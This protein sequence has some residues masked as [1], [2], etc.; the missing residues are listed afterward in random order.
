MLRYRFVATN[1]RAQERRACPE[2]RRACVR[3][4]F[5]V[6]I[7]L[8]TGA[9]DRRRRMYTPIDAADVDRIDPDAHCKE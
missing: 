1:R 3:Q 7:R 8:A 2:E 4:P 6:I 5:P 9:F